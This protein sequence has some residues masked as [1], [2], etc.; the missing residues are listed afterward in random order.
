MIEASKLKHSASYVIGCWWLLAAVF[1]SAAS[2]THLIAFEAGDTFR[3]AAV[4]RKIRVRRIRAE[5]TIFRNLRWMGN[6]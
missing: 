1:V 5:R 2:T 4:I 6:K 3:I